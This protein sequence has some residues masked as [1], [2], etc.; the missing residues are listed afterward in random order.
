MVKKYARVLESREIN[1]RTG[2]IWK[3]DD[4]PNTWKAKTIAKIEADGYKIDED[5]TVIPDE[6]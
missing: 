3:I 1:E 2:E 6:D 4:V 5:G